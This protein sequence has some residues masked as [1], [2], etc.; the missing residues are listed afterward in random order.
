MVCQVGDENV[1]QPI[2]L[3]QFQLELLEFVGKHLPEP[4]LHNLFEDEVGLLLIPC[5]DEKISSKVVHALAVAYLL[6]EIGKCAK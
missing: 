1:E 2:E 4:L 5:F 6:V 3:V